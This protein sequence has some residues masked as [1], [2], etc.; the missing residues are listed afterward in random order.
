MTTFTSNKNLI[1]GLT[2]GDLQ[3]GDIYLLYL[4]DEPLQVTIASIGI[5]PNKPALPELV[6]Y[7][8]TATTQGNLI[9]RGEG[10]RHSPIAFGRVEEE[11]PTP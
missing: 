5:V 9:F 8:V 11:P 6:L 4:N 10:Y 3:V 1:P 2:L 7:Q